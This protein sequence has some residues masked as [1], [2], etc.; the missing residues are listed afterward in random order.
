MGK[1]VKNS[2]QAQKQN[3]FPSWI[4]VEFVV[5]DARI[6]PGHKGLPNSPGQF[7]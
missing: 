7:G 6:L 3:S 5:F 4:G 2:G 1:I